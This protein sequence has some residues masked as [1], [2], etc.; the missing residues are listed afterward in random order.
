MYNA[1]AKSIMRREVE[2]G[3]SIMESGLGS[4]SLKHD[5]KVHTWI[6]RGTI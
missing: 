6:V 2:A 3:Y 1:T 5:N 4:C